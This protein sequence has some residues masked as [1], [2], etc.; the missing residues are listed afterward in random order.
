MT[1]TGVL[2]VEGEERDD[3]TKQESAQIRAR[4][5]RL[6]GSLLSPLRLRVVLTMLVVVVSTAAQVAGPALIAFG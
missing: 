3:F 1:N 2:G 6:L 5:L 4:S